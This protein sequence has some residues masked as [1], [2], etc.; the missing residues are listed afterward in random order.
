MNYYKFHIGDY[1]SHTRHLSLEEDL[2]Y[3]RLLDLYYLKEIPLCPDIQR[4]SRVIMIDKQ[5]VQS[6]LDEFF[7]YD[8]SGWINKRAHEEI[9][10]YH[11]LKAASSRGGKKTQENSKHKIIN[12]EGIEF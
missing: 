10:S 5:V 9:K 6:V 12:K 1:Q 2:C 4:L 8:D 11:E 7:I 3:R